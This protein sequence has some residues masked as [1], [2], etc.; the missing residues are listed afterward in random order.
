MKM[1]KS[2]FLPFL[3]LLVL[4]F[5]VS[6]DETEDAAGTVL[7]DIADFP[8]S[9][10][11]VALVVVNTSGDAEGTAEDTGDL[12][13]SRAFGGATKKYASKSTGTF[14][15]A[16]KDL[17]S[18]K[19]VP[20]SL[21]NS[22]RADAR[23]LTPS[24]NGITETYDHVYQYG[25]EGVIKTT[26]VTR[27]WT[28][29]HCYIFCQNQFASK[30]SSADW[31]TLGDQFDANYEKMTAAF[32]QPTDIDVNGKV[33]ITYFDMAGLTGDP[34]MVDVCGYFYGG[35]LYDLSSYD[36]KTNCMDVINMNFT[37]GYSASVGTYNVLK[38]PMV[39]T[40]VHE[41][42][43]LINE[44]N[45]NYKG[46]TMMDTWLDEGLA[47]AAEELCYTVLSSRIEQFNADSDYPGYEDDPAATSYYIRNGN[48]L[49]VWDQDYADYAMSYLFM[50]YARLQCAGDTT[51]Y[52]SLI[53][54]EKGDYSG[55]TSIVTKANSS[56]SSFKDI[57]R[58]YYL[59]NY[60]QAQSGVYAYSADYPLTVSAPTKEIGELLPSSAVYLK[61]DL[62]SIEEAVK[63]GA[64]GEKIEYALVVDGAVYY[65]E[66]GRWVKKN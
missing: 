21:Q 17:P 19:R 7:E 35:D 14:Q 65:V 40:L 64:Q 34:A 3:I 66:N 15:Q 49:V 54:G 52:K 55:I 43:H 29:T 44:G 51:I 45:R 5:G 10:T 62:S 32:G 58:G 41:F 9:G 33:V 16:L 18:G 8:T 60:V 57:V 48:S 28:G 36:M 2:W 31:K 27:V 61:S 39:T 63:L 53:E 42:E 59:A 25:D 22:S 13:V 11:D 30:L 12:P 23:A 38:E 20:R 47:Q 56:F 4:A 46:K 1:N 24:W 37:W 26:T 6:C 50:Q